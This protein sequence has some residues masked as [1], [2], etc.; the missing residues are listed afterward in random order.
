MSYIILY[1]L[2]NNTTQVL[3]VCSRNTG[4]LSLI[5]KYIASNTNKLP[6]CTGTRNSFR[7]IWLSVGWVA[8]LTETKT[9]PASWGL[10]ELGNISNSFLI[11]NFAFFLQIFA[12][13]FNY[14]NP[15]LYLKALKKLIYQTNLWP[16]AR[17]TGQTCIQYFEKT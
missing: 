14:F 9:K 5:V 15:W 1:Y 13:N 6:F 16:L 4:A 17:V 3:P 2:N 12:S 8:G 10:A 11:D 7:A